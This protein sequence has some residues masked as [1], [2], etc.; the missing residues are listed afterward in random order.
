MIFGIKE[1]SIIFDPYNVFLANAT[2]KPGDLRLVL[3]SR[4][5]YLVYLLFIWLV[6]RIFIYHLF[7]Y[8]IVYFISE[9][10]NHWIIYLIHKSYVNLYLLY[11]NLVNQLTKMHFVA[12]NYSICC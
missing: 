10:F 5:T 12:H 6:Y 8:V 11:M 1:K 4:V 9:L 3:C 7:Y 2:N